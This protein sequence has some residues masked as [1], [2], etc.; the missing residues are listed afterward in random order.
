MQTLRCI[1]CFCGIA[2]EYPHRNEVA[3]VNTKSCNPNHKLQY[4]DCLLRKL[5]KPDPVWRSPEPGVLGCGFSEM[6]WSDVGARMRLC[7]SHPGGIQPN[8]I[9][10]SNHAQKFCVLESSTRY[11]GAHRPH[12]V[13][14]LVGV[15]FIHRKGSFEA[16]ACGC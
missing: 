5:S 14:S 8:P 9:A 3:N 12:G 13:V 7:F 2:F 1:I 6:L 10:G 16:S 11:V 4:S 15:R